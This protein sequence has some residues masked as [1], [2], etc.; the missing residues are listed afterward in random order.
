MITFS[1]YILKRNNT[2]FEKMKNEKMKIHYLDCALTPAKAQG[3]SYQLTPMVIFDP[4]RPL[5]SDYLPE[6][7]LWTRHYDPH[8]SPPYQQASY[9][10][11]CD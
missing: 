6:Y 9:K 2:T 7:L 1:L 5:F 11:V 3:R 8:P 4:Q 10:I